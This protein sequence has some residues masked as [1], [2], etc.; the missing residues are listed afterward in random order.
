VL[1]DLSLGCID[2]EPVATHP[3]RAPMAANG[4]R[5]R[6]ARM[7]AVE[8]VREIV[9]GYFEAHAAPPAV[10]VSAFADEI[11]IEIDADPMIYGP[12]ARSLRDAARRVAPNVLVQRRRV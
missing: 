12:L 4:R 11:V 8:C 3:Y 7:S 1:L 9:T 2:A 5:E 10:D 6:T